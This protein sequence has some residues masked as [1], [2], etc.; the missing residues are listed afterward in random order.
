MTELEFLLLLLKNPNA[1]DVML[2]SWLM[3]LM[4]NSVALLR[5][6]CTPS[7]V[8]ELHSAYVTSRDA[9]RAFPSL[10]DTMSLPSDALLLLE[11]RKQTM[12]HLFGK[13]TDT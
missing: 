13:S 11:E 2:F 6:C 1:F 3:K 8:S 12:K 5:A 10:V 7:F 4:A 9:A